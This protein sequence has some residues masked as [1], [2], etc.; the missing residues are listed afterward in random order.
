MT[1]IIEILREEHRNIEELL[2]VLEQELHVFDSR[3]RR[4]AQA[5]SEY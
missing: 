4:A 1:K 2:L 5:S 3:L